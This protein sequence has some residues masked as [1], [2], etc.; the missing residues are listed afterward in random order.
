MGEENFVSISF[1]WRKSEL[2]T[3]TLG[4][5]TRLCFVLSAPSSMRHDHPTGDPSELMRRCDEWIVAHRHRLLACARQHADA[6][7]DVDLLLADTLRKV[8]RV[9]CRRR[10][11]E[12]LMVRYTMRSLRNA[13]RDAHRHNMRRCNAEEQ[14]RQDEQD[15]RLQ[16]ESPTGVN[17]VH[18]AL[19]EILRQ[20]PPP[21]A[22]VLTLKLWQRMTFADMAAQ[23]GVAESTVRRYYETAIEL[24]RK[25]MSAS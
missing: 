23:L 12:E 9:F 19:R 4:K 13:A 7:T 15:H 10:M 17:E 3:V 1:L 18:A 20:L 22:E 21:Y 8:A 16:R 25:R 14:Y 2:K 11:S 24:V 5:G 6:M